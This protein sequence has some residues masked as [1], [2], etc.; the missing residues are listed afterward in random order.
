MSVH[1]ANISTSK[2]GLAVGGRIVSDSLFLIATLAQ[3][4][5]DHLG[6]VSLGCRKKM[7]WQGS[8]AALAVFK[9]WCDNTKLCIRASHGCLA[10]IGKKESLNRDEVNHNSDVLGPLVRHLGSLP[11]TL[12]WE[13]NNDHYISL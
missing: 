4:E 12:K 5:P 6:C 13:S 11:K 3:T 9:D 7:A 10:R 1:T 8:P 2:L